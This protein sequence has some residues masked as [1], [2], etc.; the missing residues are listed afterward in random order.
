MPPEES[1]D[2][3]RSL[4]PLEGRLRALPPLPV[5]AGLEARLLRTL[6]GTRRR[7]GRWV[8]VAAGVAA[9][10]CLFL[11]LHQRPEGPGTS[12]EERGTREERTEAGGSVASG[13][14]PLASRPSPLVLWRE[15][16]RLEDETRSAG[17]TWPLETTATV[18]TPPAA[19]TG[20]AD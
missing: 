1:R 19:L 14:A 6:P 13:P 12:N 20:S 4:D 15:S 5:P 3:D 11:A 2:P 17:F 18:R 10:A 9:A 7:R 16:R 8:G